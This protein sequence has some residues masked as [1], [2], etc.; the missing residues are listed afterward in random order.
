MTRAEEYSAA[1]AACAQHDA[2]RR[3]RKHARFLES[4]GIARTKSVRRE[5]ERKAVEHQDTP[6]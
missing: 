6:A 1:L 3:A 5:I 2:V 4:G